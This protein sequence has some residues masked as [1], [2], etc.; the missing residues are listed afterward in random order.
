MGSYEKSLRQT[1]EGL[2]GQ[3]FLLDKAVKKVVQLSVPGLDKASLPQDGVNAELI[4]AIAMVAA[5]AQDIRQMAV[6]ALATTGKVL[7][8][9]DNNE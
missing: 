6:I 9:L 4:T 2:S 7:S 3:L 1:L 8:C 5:F